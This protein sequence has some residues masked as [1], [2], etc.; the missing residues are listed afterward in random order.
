MMKYIV[1]TH[2]VYVCFFFLL[3]FQA[4]DLK[5]QILKDSGRYQK[6]VIMTR[7]KP[8]TIV[9]MIYNVRGLL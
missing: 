5:I 4:N 1:L 8:T 2:H 7:K 9:D 6:D 3:C